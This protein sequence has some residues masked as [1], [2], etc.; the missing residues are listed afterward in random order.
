MNISFL[1]KYL[2]YKWNQTFYGKLGPAG[3]KPVAGALNREEK[4]M[5]IRKKKTTTHV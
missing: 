3:L 5:K 4:N 2:R 1:K